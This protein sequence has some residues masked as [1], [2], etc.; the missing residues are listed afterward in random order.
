MHEKLSIDTI[1]KWGGK[2]VEQG[3]VNQKLVPRPKLGPLCKR[4]GKKRVSRRRTEEEIIQVFWMKIDVKGDDECWPCCANH[5]IRGYKQTKFRGRAEYAH[6]VAYILAVQEI[7][8]EKWVLHRCD[9]P[10]CCNPKHLFLGTPK[11][12]AID[13][14]RKGRNGTNGKRKINEDQARRIK[15][16]LL[17]G[18]PLQRISDEFPMITRSGVESIKRGR[19]WAH[20]T[21]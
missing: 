2:A 3:R 19:S 17:T 4:D 9:N 1:R 10:A 15:R 20:I 18:C 12:N 5:S 14:K 13:R 21:I 8:D 6:R 7:P 16:L 11:D